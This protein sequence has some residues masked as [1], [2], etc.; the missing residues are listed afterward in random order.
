MT[1]KQFQTKKLSA[2]CTLPTY[3]WMEQWFNDRN[4]MPYKMKPEDHLKVKTSDRFYLSKV[5]ET[6]LNKICKDLGADPIKAPDKGRKITQNGKDIFIKVK[7]VKK[8]RADVKCFVG[9]KMWNFEVKAP[10]DRMSEEQKVEEQRCIANG[11]VYFIVKSIDEIKDWYL[12]ITTHP[13]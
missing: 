12:S 13:Q 10:G 1:D 4:P 5:M 9:G 8:G 6:L 7:G 3:L 2:I 11:E